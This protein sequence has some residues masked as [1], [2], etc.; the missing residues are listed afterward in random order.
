MVD[1]FSWAPPPP[2][3]SKLE[4]A[5]WQFHSD[6]QH[7]YAKLVF[8]AR[9]F[10]R[11]HKHGSINLLFERVRWDYLTSTAT[12][13]G[14]KLNNNHRAFY[15]RLIEEREPD[16]ANFFRMRQQRMQA[17]FGPDNSMLPPGVHVSP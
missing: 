11:V 4:M 8:Y 12:A 13:D 14:F 3:P 7:V 6:N 15:A 5:F 9:Q 2:S 1:L 16:L 17:T 10:A